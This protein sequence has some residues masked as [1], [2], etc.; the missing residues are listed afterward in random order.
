[1]IRNRRIY[2]GVLVAIFFGG[3]MELTDALPEEMESADALPEEQGLADALPEHDGD[4]KTTPTTGVKQERR[5]LI[6]VYTGD[7]KGKT[8]AAI[9]LALRAT[10]QNIPVFIVQFMK[11]GH[12]TGEL[13]AAERFLQGRMTFRQFGRGCIRENMQTQ[14][15]AF[16][17]QSPAK[18][19]QSVRDD[20]PC[21][22][23]RY[24]FVNDKTQM[25]LCEDAAAVAKKAASSGEYGMVIMDE[26]LYAIHYGMLP[27]ARLLEVM[28]AKA[29]GVELVITGGNAPLEVIELADLVTNMTRVK[30]YY[31]EQGILARRGVEY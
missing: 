23:C 11:G 17:E 18:H 9:G 8:T 10:G 28:T 1:L 24:C 22:D 19:H 30:H 14:L 27:L 26:V 13:L 20:E 4:L 16:D 15:A 6:H 31:A 29:P 2:T 7:G 21:G 12:Y 25:E 5:G 3:K